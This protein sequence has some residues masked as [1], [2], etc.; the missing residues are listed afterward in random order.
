MLG[1]HGLQPGVGLGTLGGWAQ[2]VGG[3][4]H[5]DGVLQVGSGLQV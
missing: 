4:L 1:M 5:L 3:G 2:V